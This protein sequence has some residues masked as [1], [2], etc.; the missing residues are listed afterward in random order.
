MSETE[1]HAAAY[2]WIRTVSGEKVT[3]FDLD[4]RHVNI[5]DISHSL[6]RICRFGG[7]TY[8]FLSVA[9][10]SVAV[11]HLVPRELALT[12]LLHDA[13]EAYLGDLVRPLKKL[14]EM[15]VYREAE[16]RAH[17]AIARAFGTVYPHPEAIKQADDGRLLLEIEH[18]RDV[19]VG[20]LPDD[21]KALFLERYTELQQ[22]VRPS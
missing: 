14:P 19:P 9:E 16:E 17:A 5:V 18:M 3:P 13:S 22:V 1:V 12:A 7:H 8:G 15:A 2:G 10:H 6:A 11:S 21:A 4:W 20:L